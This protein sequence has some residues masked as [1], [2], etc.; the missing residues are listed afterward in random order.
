V[1]SAPEFRFT[2]PADDIASQQRPVVESYILTE[3][4]LEP[5]N[6]AAIWPAIS[7][8]LFCPVKAKAS[9]AAPLAQI[10]FDEC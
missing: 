10:F 5:K 8:Y 7:A 2:L 1:D 6:Q 4:V 9:A 3:T